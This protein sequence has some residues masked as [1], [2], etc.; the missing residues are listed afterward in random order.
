MG[1]LLDQLTIEAIS[2]ASNNW[3]SGINAVPS[4]CLL[5]KLDKDGEFSLSSISLEISTNGSSSDSQVLDT[6][7]LCFG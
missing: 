5:Q 4:D 7:V 1:L 3:T 6:S 2:C